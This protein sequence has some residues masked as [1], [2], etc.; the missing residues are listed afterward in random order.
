MELTD[1]PHG[2]PDVEALLG[3]HDPHPLQ[4]VRRVLADA[5]GNRGDGE[6]RGVAGA[7]VVGQV[8][9]GVLVGDEHGSGSVDGLRVGEDTG[10]EDDHRTL[11]LDAHAGM[12]ELRDPHARHST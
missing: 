6:D 1:G 9:V 10:V 8:V 7:Q 4:Q 12:A 2:D 5:G 11:V 3:S